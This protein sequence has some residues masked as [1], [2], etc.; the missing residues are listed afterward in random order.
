MCDRNTVKIPNAQVSQP[1]N[2]SPCFGPS[3][4][5][6][7]FACQLQ[8]IFIHFYR[9]LQSLLY[10]DG[11]YATASCLCVCLSVCESVTM[12]YNYHV[13]WNTSKIIITRLISLGY[14]LSADSNISLLAFFKENTTKFFAGIRVRYGKSSSRC[15]NYAMS[16]EKL[17]RPI[18]VELYFIVLLGPKHLRKSIVAMTC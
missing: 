18:Y 14:S 2:Y 15:T 3:R 17:H 5:G 6:G 1:C 12:R 16:S 9:T 4:T 10:A 13:G 7:A 11:G 8:F